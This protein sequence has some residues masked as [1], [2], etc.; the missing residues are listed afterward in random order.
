MLILKQ[1]A[2]DYDV[3]QAEL[4]SIL[5]VRQPDISRMMSGLRE[6]RPEHI[7]LLEARFGKD[8]VAHYN[9]SDE[10]YDEWRN[11]AS[12]AITATIVPAEVVEEIK[13]VVAEE[14][15]EAESIPV[16]TGDVSTQ[17]GVDI[18]AYVEENR[19]NLKR[20]NL[21]KRVKHA[22]HAEEVSDMSM[23]PT[24][25]PGDSVF[26][27]YLPDKEMI[28][29]GAIYYFNT[30]RR[31]SMVRKVKIEGDNLRLIADNP[32][33]DDI[34]VPRKNVIR[35]AEVVG[36]FRPFISSFNSELE[37]ARRQKDQQ[38]ENLIGQF[39]QWGAREN[40]LIDIIEKRE[41]LLTDMINKTINQ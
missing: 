21:S 16:V 27:R 28:S 15:I 38:I 25:L 36:M 12:K 11:R 31:S 35:V 9:L 8:V 14:I 24:L 41:S 30:K 19:E 29:D 5:N 22:K 13:E 23:A 6:I 18:K 40:R 7:E 20:V 3:T 4:A 32:T 10:Q 17:V 34:V 2:K 1:L 39:A 37:M 33:F 26:V